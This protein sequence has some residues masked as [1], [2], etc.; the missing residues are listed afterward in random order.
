MRILR[1]SMKLNRGS[2]SS[3]VML[4]NRYSCSDQPVDAPV[5]KQDTHAFCNEPERS[6]MCTSL[7]PGLDIAVHAACTRFLHGAVV[8]VQ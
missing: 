5:G 7:T 2:H 8:H 3:R 4:R 6:A 1:D